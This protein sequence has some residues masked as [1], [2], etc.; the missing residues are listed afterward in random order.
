MPDV[1]RNVWGAF[2]AGAVLLTLHFGLAEADELPSAQ[3]FSQVARG[4]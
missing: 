3:D 1:L 2:A 4:H